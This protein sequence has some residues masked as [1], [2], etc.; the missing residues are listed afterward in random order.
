MNLDDAK[1]LALDLMQ[2]HITAKPPRSLY[3][4]P[5]P[6]KCWSFKF[7]NAKRRF[8][9]CHYHKGHISLSRSLVLLNSVEQVTDTILHEIAHVNVGGGHG[10]DEVWQREALRLGADGK[11]C[12]DSTK[13]PMPVSPWMGQCPG[14]K[15]QFR[16]WRR[17]PARSMS[18][19]ICAPRRY[20]PQ[21]QLQWS[22]TII[23]GLEAYAESVGLT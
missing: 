13:V 19:G 12:F 6:Y 20:D 22:R 8:G 1:T 21:F 5:S 10:H 9:Q 11:A 2:K 18:C 3:T 7:D 16:R 23:R 14:C 17:P 4:G 15:K